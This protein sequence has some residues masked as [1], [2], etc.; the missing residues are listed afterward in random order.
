MVGEDETPNEIADETPDTGD[1]H[2]FLLGLAGRVSDAVIARCRGL[3]ADGRE[4]D[5]APALI[6]GVLDEA[7]PLFDTEVDFL[8]DAMG[9]T[10]D[11][12]E[13]LSRMTTTESGVPLGY[14]FV[15][16]SPP[17]DSGIGGTSAE[18]DRVAIERTAAL[19]GTIG[20][21]RAWRLP[22][23]NSASQ[24]VA[25]VCV[26]EADEDADLISVTGELQRSLEAI[27]QADP[28]VEVYPTGFELPSYHRFA[29]AYGAL[30]W[31]RT[32][33]PGVRIAVLFDEVDPTLGPRF[34]EDHPT[35][36]DGE[37]EE[38]VEYLHQGQ[39]LLVTTGRLDDVV[40]PARG[41]VVPMTFRTDGTWVWSDATTY[42]L[43]T[44][45][46]LPDPDMV[47]HIRALDYELPDVTD[48]AVHRAMAALQEP[49]AEEPAWTFGG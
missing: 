8:G 30:L 21:W 46:L 14:G 23:A 34:D 44:Y 26:V 29:R 40:E 12:D 17:E 6:M 18:A 11:A 5:L 20:L 7:V 4:T 42:Y 25:R 27:G 43:E 33:D 47:A 1:W 37:W 36:D 45:H 3:L 22:T 32:P 16:E 48:V 39:P 24:Q 2:L 31:S 15:A 19:T 35:V 49:A 41:N 38:L 10:D 9:W 28:Q 13:L